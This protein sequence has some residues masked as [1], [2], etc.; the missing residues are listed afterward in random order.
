MTLTDL[1]ATYGT[2]TYTFKLSGGALGDTTVN[3]S[4]VG[5]AYSNMALVT[6]Y[7]ALQGVNGASV[8]FDL[9]GMTPGTGSNQANIFLYIYNA[10][11]NALVY[12]SGALSSGTTMIP[13]G[14]LAAGTQYYYNLEYDSRIFDTIDDGT[15]AQYQ[16]YDMDTNGNFYTAGAVPEPSTWAMLIVGFGGIGFMMRR[17]ALALAKAA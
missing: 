1:Q 15:I 2:G 3:Q 17:R 14:A 13:V 16:I 5:G 12:A 9:N 6:N 7:S 10:S 11:T 8:T 4:Y